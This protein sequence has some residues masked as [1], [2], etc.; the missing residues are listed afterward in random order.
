MS[1][2]SLL[3]LW[4]SDPHPL[5]TAVAS[6][7]IDMVLAEDRADRDKERGVHMAAVLA[8]ALLCPALL[9]CAAYGVTPLVR[10]G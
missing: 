2:D 6:T 4:T 7:A 5:T 9:W 3:A 8:L 10:G 1:D